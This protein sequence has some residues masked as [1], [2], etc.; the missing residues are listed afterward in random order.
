M[1]LIIAGSRDAKVTVKD[2]DDWI[3][4]HN[5]KPTLIISGGSGNVDLTGE[6]WAKENNIPVRVFPADWTKY[7]KS[8]GP[9]RNIQMAEFGDSLLAF[10]DVN[11]R[12]TANMIENMNQLDK[13]VYIV[14]V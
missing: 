6:K 3:R 13:P 10:W 1:K 5:L 9:R 8:A 7:G 14:E 12:G 2:I 11:S 4:A